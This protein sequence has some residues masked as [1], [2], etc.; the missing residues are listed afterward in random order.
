[1]KYPPLYGG[2]IIYI[3]QPLR[4]YIERLTLTRELSAKLAEG[5]KRGAWGWCGAN[6]A[7]GIKK[8]VTFHVVL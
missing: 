5:E 7:G 3:V 1:M 2:I 6:K 8:K 4:G